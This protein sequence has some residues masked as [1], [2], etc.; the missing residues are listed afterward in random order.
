MPGPQDL[1]ARNRLL[2]DKLPI[3]FNL[4]ESGLQIPL[5]GSGAFRYGWLAWVNH[6]SLGRI[7][8][9]IAL[10][11]GDYQER[12]GV[13]RL[14]LLDQTPLAVRAA[15]MTSSWRGARSRVR[16]GKLAGDKVNDFPGVDAE[17]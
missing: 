15:A 16:K 17:N 12:D 4:G 7:E 11:V 6:E 13:V 14:R 3:R 9:V 10:A 8:P 2:I 1:Q 5:L